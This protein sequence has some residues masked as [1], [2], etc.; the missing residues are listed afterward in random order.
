[1]DDARFTLGALI[2]GMGMPQD[3]LVAE[4]RKRAK[5]KALEDAAHVGP[6]GWGLQPTT[7]GEGEGEEKSLALVRRQRRGAGITSR[8]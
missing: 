8:R 5:A 2:V 3:V 1:V 4:T 7:T 6:K